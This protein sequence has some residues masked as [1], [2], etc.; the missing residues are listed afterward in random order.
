MSKINMYIT[1]EQPFE[2]RTFT[3]DQMHEVYRDL[4]D[5]KEYPDFTDWLI[6]M[7][8]SGVF[9]IIT[10][11]LNALTVQEVI[12]SLFSDLKKVT[13]ADIQ[14]AHFIINLVYR[15]KLYESDA[16]KLAKEYCLYGSLSL[17]QY[18]L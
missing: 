7:L 1:Y 2:G 17:N 4:A 12:Y 8:K 10:D 5:K 6:D 13:D 16:V 3:S 18:E 15:T 9:E 11:G 14:V